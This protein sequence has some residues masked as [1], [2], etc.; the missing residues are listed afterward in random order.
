MKAT[1]IVWLC[2]KASGLFVYDYEPDAPAYGTA[3]V[4]IC[5]CPKDKPDKQSVA[6]GDTLYVNGMVS[7]SHYCAVFK[8]FHP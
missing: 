8:E 5:E 7:G 1:L 2:L 6:P 4:E 3:T